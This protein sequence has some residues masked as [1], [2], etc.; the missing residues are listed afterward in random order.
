LLA[1]GGLVSTSK[2]CPF[3]IVA[4]TCKEVRSSYLVA[5]SHHSFGMNLVEPAM[6]VPREVGVGHGRRDWRCSL[7]SVVGLQLCH[8]G[9]WSIGSP[10]PFRHLE[11]S[12]HFINYYKWCANLTFI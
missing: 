10:E 5:F 12:N 4:S 2:A 8:R 6:L 3:G 1:P 7:R 11:N 9:Q